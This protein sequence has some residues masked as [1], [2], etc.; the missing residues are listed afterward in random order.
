MKGKKR[1]EEEKNGGSEVKESLKKRVKGGGKTTSY[2]LHLIPVH[3]CITLSPEPPLMSRSGK[4][5]HQFRHQ[6]ASNPDITEN[7]KILSKG[8]Q[9]FEKVD[10]LS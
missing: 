7:L 8:S 4:F 2:H 5:L 6:P 1:R 9:I 3:M 10:I